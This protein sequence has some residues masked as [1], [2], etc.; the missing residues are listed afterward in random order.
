MLYVALAVRSPDVLQRTSEAERPSARSQHQHQQNKKQNKTDMSK[1]SHFGSR[2]YSSSNPIMKRSADN[3]DNHQTLLSLV[4]VR[5]LIRSYPGEVSDCFSK[6]V[7][8]DSLD[9]CS[10]YYDIIVKGCVPKKIGSGRI[11]VRPYTMECVI[12]MLWDRLAAIVA[13][14]VRRSAMAGALH[15]PRPRVQGWGKGR[16]VPELSPA[17]WDAFHGV[18]A[19]YLGGERLADAEPTSVDECASEVS[20]LSCMV[21]GSPLDDGLVRGHMCAVCAMVEPSLFL[22]ATFARCDVME[23]L[24]G[25]SVAHTLRRHLHAWAFDRDAPPAVDPTEVFVLFSSN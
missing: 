13:K 14:H 15:G 16:G 21:V 10:A 23:E 12:A 18:I 17:V 22:A 4:E 19:K 20:E 8:Q 1:R 11:A 25:Q 3:A 9:R 6:D 24:I 7:I 2:T 5:D